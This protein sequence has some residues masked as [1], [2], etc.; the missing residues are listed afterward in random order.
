MPTP[1]PRPWHR[2]SLFG[3]GPRRPL[4]REQRARFRFLLGAHA[5]ANRLPS[6][7]EK[8]GM[9]LLRRLGVDGQCDP[10][11][12]TLAQDSGTSCR[13]VRR[14][15]ATLRELGLL[16]WRNRLVRAGWRAA[17]TS[18]AY[19]LVPRAENPAAACGGQS[20]RQTHKEA[21]IL[22]VL[23]A[24]SSQNA[25]DAT[26]ARAALARRRAVIEGRLLMKGAR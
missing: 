21:L 23:L 19:E 22:P 17:Q 26:E 5:R 6:K 9:A 25:M 2:G 13:T 3:A 11:Q 24:A 7:Q 10:S 14:A 18:N 4:D 8:V 16:R 15:T 20:G 12:D 1:H